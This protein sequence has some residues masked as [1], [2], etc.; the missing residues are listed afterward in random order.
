MGENK[1]AIEN[2]SAYAS[3]FLYFFFLLLL[4]DFDV[5]LPNVRFYEGREQKKI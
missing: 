2:N 5:K 1:L 4:Q 3:C